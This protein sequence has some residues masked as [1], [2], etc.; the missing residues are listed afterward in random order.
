MQRRVRLSL[1]ATAVVAVVCAG[2]HAAL[3]PSDRVPS[4]AVPK[5]SKPPKIDGVID[6]AEWAES[7]A[8]SGVAN[9]ADNH[10]IPRPTTYFL[11]WDEGHF[12]WACRTWVMPGYKPRVRGRAPHAAGVFEDSMELHFKPMGKNVPA[13]RTDSSYKFFI[14]P[15]GYDGDSTRIA[16][17]QQFKNWIPEFDAA[18]R[19]T[20]PGS[21][22]KGGRWLEVEIAASP[23]DFELDGPNRAGDQWRLM[24]GFNHMCNDWMQARVPCNSSYFDPSGYCLVTLVDDA[25]AVK[26]LME[27]VP[28]PMD[29]QAAVRFE[30]FNPTKQKVEVKCLAQFTDLGDKDTEPADLLKTERTLAIEPGKN[31]VF[32]VNEKLPRLL[33]KRSGSIFYSVTQDNAEL[34]RYFTFFRTEYPKRW[35]TYTPPKNPFPLIGTFNP[36]ESN[37]VLEADAYYLDNRDDA[38]SVTYRILRDG[39]KKPVVEGAIG[40]AV[41]Y[42]YRRLVQ[43]PPLKGGAYRVEAVM[44]FKDGKTL[45]PVATGFKKLNE[46]KEYAEWW[47]NNLGHI[48]RVIPPFTAMKREGAAVSTWG[49]TYTLGKLGLPAAVLSQGEPVLAAPVRIVVVSGG[50]E[51]IVE[52]KGEPTFTETKEWRVRFEGK[53]EGAPLSLAARGWVEQDGM[54]QV[55]LT[56]GPAG[57]K[58]VQLDALRLE[59]PLAARDAECLL[60]LG[61]G[62]NF[63][64]RTT[65]VLPPEKQGRLWSTF[66]TGAKGSGMAVGSFY[67]CI[68]VGNERRGLLWYANNDKGWVPDDEVPAHEVLREG[69]QVVLRNNLIGKPFTLA[70]PRTVTLCFMASPFRPLVKNWRVSIKSENGTF[71]G[72]P[73]WGGGLGYKARK[74]PKTGQV[75]DGWNLLTPPS[76]KPE[77]WSGIWAEYKKRADARERQHLPFSPTQARRWRYSHTSLPLMGYGWKS[78]D[79]R[80][81]DYF[82]A[83]WAGDAWTKTEREYFL[84]VADRAFREGGLR[85]IYSDIFFIAA[86]KN[87]QNGLAYQLPDGRIQPGFNAMNIRRFMMRMYALMHDHG[88]T[89][90]SQ[91]SHATNCYCLPA[92]GWMDAILDGEYAL[93]RDDSPLDWV[94]QYP[95]E[96]MRSMSCPQNFGTVISWMNLIKVTDK[97][98]LRRIIVGG[99]HYLRL[100]DTWYGPSWWPGMPESILDWGLCDQRCQY[101][102]FWRNQQVT[103]EDK[104]VLVSVWTLPDRVLIGVFNHNNKQAKNVTLNVDLRALGLTP[105]LKWQEFVG[106]R[107]LDPADAP[108]P[109]LD[110]YAGKLTVQ[111]LAPHTGRFIGIRLY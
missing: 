96:R 16:V 12:Y 20:E 36:V 87:I 84:Y 3:V 54:A 39:E 41:T 89:P 47:N 73:D 22:P 10:L 93:T 80:V 7:A 82:T 111:D 33:D 9:Q 25:P 104:E 77:E 44:A 107:L 72:G 91:V 109:K 1:L 18:A 69:N 57:G 43:M 63:S 105:K 49:R 13:G 68:W 53:A 95:I 58:P 24:L 88:L 60:C 61:P 40:D 103:C 97:E 38:K 74:D 37:F 5:M 101:V 51:T 67:P 52:A 76:P 34:L 4:C 21:A 15:A 11:S 14:N 106:V 110:F 56:Y 102:P 78:P 32:I 100:Y 71:S 108:K 28:G 19:L 86:F 70:E 29:G 75:F 79:R 81:T 64:A 8:F 45:G 42:Y 92:C 65:I 30:I 55:E 23:D 62:G 90:G 66:D 98:R 50:K 48:E 26:V 27:S 35:M 17:G 2:A 99:A 31:A 59:F 94:D 6:P 83:D 85:T 46:A